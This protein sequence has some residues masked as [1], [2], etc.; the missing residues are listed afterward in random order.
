MNIYSQVDYTTPMYN[1]SVLYRQ[2]YSYYN[3]ISNIYNS[4]LY[5]TRD[6]IPQRNLSLISRPN[7]YGYLD[8]YQVQ[9]NQPQRQIFQASQAC[10]RY[11]PLR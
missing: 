2:E 3:N 1:D 5:N 7:R 8:P 4:N 10:C 11:P 9:A 6:G